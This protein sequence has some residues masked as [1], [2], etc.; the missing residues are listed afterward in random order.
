MKKYA[1]SVTSNAVRVKMEDSR[2]GVET[3]KEVS[4]ILRK[5]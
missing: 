3:R 5:K 2:G 4:I 1:A